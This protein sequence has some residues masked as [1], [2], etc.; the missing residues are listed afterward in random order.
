MGRKNVMRWKKRDHSEEEYRDERRDHEVHG[1]SYPI[2]DVKAMPD[3]QN[4]RVEQSASKRTFA[5]NIG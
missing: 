1:G 2:E 4:H 5:L 3:Y